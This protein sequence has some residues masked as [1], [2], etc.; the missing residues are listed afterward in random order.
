MLSW[1]ETNVSFDYGSG[2]DQIMTPFCNRFEDGRANL[3][4]LFG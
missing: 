3:L 2:L 4:V 1:L